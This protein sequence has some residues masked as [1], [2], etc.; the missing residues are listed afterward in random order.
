LL[1]SH[2]S[3]LHLYGKVEARIGRKMGHFNTL[4]EKLEDA[5]QEANKIFK[6]L[7]A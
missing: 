5:Q 2:S 7:P 3:K 6:N 4:S 1:N